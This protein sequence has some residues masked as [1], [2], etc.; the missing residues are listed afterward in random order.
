MSIS[1]GP[2]APPDPGDPSKR[3]PWVA[4]G[5]GVLVLVLVGG[6]YLSA[7]RSP[8]VTVNVAGTPTT[9]PGAA[10]AVLTSTAL[11]TP[12]PVVVT[13]VVTATPLPAP[14]RPAPTPTSPTA[15]TAQPAPTATSLVVAA[16]PT[17]PPLAPTPPPAPTTPPTV[18]A[19]PTSAAPASPTPFAGQ[20]A[21]AGGLGNTRADVDAAYGPPTGQTPD[22]LVVYRK[23]A[24]EY[25]VEFVPDLN[26]RAAVLE[27]IPQSGAPPP[28]L[29]SA[30][31]QAHKLLPKDAQP[32]SAQQ[33]GNDQYVVERYMSPTLAQ[34][35]PAQTFASNKAQPGQIMVVYV[36]DT[37]QAGS[38]SRIIVGPGSDASALIGV[39]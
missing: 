12:T 11:P 20:V 29:E 5:L 16:Q 7:N 10:A 14:I 35:L 37:A 17:Q 36:R 18:A 21:N 1:A 33:E 6:F 27:A 31:T 9:N 34:A 30:T 28:T 2:A 25:H 39:S 38:I 32:P 22:H 19:S 15:S 4:L 24:V 8:T 23:A 13:V 3:W 26:G